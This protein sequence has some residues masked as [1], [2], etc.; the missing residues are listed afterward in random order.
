MQMN[1]AAE[2]T[3]LLGELLKKTTWPA[4]KGTPFQLA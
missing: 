1:V 2:Q 4:R 3:I